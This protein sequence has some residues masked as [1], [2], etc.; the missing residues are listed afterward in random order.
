EGQTL[1]EALQGAQKLLRSDPRT[2]HP[3]FWAP[4]VLIGDAASTL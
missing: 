2:A 1:S 3:I 4:F